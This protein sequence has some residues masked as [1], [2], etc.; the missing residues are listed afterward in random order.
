MT[1]KQSDA[2]SVHYFARSDSRF[3]VTK[4]CDWLPLAHAV[5]L[6]YFCLSRVYENAKV[7]PHLGAR[8]ATIFSM[9]GSPHELRFF[10]A[11]STRKEQKKMNIKDQ[12]KKTRIGDY[13]LFIVRVRIKKVKRIEQLMND[14]DKERTGLN[15]LTEQELANLNSWLDPDKVLS[16]D[17][18]PD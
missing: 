5:A 13:G 9:R 6:S 4:P 7:K 10:H 16:A 18:A 14:K 15:K 3:T 17:P 11:T 2:P 8:E 1:L 12:P